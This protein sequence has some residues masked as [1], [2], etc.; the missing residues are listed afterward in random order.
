M[1][2]KTW[3]RVKPIGGTPPKEKKLGKKNGGV[4]DIE[5]KELNCTN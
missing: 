5:I 1:L 4:A 3:W 2:S